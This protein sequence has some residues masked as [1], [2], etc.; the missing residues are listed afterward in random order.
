M[1]INKWVGY[2]TGLIVG[3]VVL[4]IGMAMKPKPVFP[5]INV[6]I[7]TD[8]SVGLILVVKF[9]GILIIGVFVVMG[10][11]ELVKSKK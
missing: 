10:I 5:N 3:G 2:F 8:Q 1:K 9:L 11:I 7:Y 4:A 6:N